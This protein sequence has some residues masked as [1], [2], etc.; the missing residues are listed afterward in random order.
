MAK[1]L[2]AAVLGA[3]V[4]TVASAR[5]PDRFSLLDKEY[6]SL[7]S[8]MTAKVIQDAADGRCFLIVF[9]ARDQIAVGP[10]VPCSH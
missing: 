1:L 3:A 5:T 2:F 8:T 10:A 7:G 4:A 9:S 6:S